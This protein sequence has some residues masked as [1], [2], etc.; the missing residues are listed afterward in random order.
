MFGD[1]VEKSLFNTI[2]YLYFWSKRCHCKT[3]IFNCDDSGSNLFENDFYFFNSDN[4]KVHETN[5]MDVCANEFDNGII[6]PETDNRYNHLTRENHEIVYNIV[7]NFFTGTNYSETF[8]K[9]LLKGG[10]EFNRF[11]YE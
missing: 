5:L 6:N 1:D 8:H 2:L 7:S 9:G 4:F 3:L 11:I 10:E